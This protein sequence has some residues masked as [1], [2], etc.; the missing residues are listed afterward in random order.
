MQ[1]D[2]IPLIGVVHLPRL[3]ETSPHTLD[4]VIEYVVNETKILENSGFSGVILENF[5]DAPFPKNRISDYVFAKLSIL[6]ARLKKETRLPIGV[7]ILR[8]ACLQAIT[9]ASLLELSFI[10]CN[11]WE[12]A[13]ITDQGIIEGAAHDVISYKNQM[14]SS[15]DIYADI[16]VKHASPLGNFDL[17]EA[18]E[19]A[20][21]RGKAD[22]VVVTGGA[23][24]KPPGVEMVKELSDYGIKPIIGS[25]L[26][27]QNLDD[28]AP[29]IQGAIVGTSIKKQYKVT[30]P[31]DQQAAETLAQ[32]W[33]E[34][35]HT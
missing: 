22:H 18:A 5:N 13:Y 20:L 30:N 19:N 16:H 14:G 3:T 1:I 23:T 21:N 17:I 8:N 24:G 7:N 34:I 32:K 29:Y 28:L 11:I 4:S 25:G 9:I 10:R 31:I 2:S 35:F 12:S 6:I 26:S 33:I 27:V 15:V